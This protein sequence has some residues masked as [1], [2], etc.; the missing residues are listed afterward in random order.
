MSQMII[1]IFAV[2]VVVITASK[3]GAQAVWPITKER[4]GHGVVGGGACFHWKTYEDSACTGEVVD[5]GGVTTGA[6]AEDGCWD[7]SNGTSYSEYCDNTGYH[8]VYFNSTDCSGDVV[9]EE[10]SWPNG[11]DKFIEN[12]VLA[13]CTVDGPCDGGGFK[14][15]E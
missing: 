13:F 2:Y 7:W 3:S 9:F 8:G 1:V 11:C 14:S 15:M 5:E 10:T 12:Y 4:M 6:S